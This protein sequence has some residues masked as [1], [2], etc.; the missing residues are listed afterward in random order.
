MNPINSSLC[1]ILNGLN[2]THFTGIHDAVS[3][4]QTV[5][6][7]HKCISEHGIKSSEI[8]AKFFSKNL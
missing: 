1:G 2:P 3:P 5:V 8:E 4:I 7:T 6:A